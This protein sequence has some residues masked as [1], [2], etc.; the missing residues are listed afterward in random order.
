MRKQNLIVKTFQVPIERKEDGT[1]VEKQVEI[2]SEMLL[3]EEP[4]E[5]K[6]PV[7]ELPTL[8]KKVAQFNE[9]QIKFAEEDSSID[10]IRKKIITK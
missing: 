5:L 6:S 1:V 8:S 9:R 4:T 3:S 7:L 2:T 10:Y